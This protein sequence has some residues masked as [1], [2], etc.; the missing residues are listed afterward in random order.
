LIFGFRNFGVLLIVI[1]KEK[2]NESVGSRNSDSS[3]YW[4][5]VEVPCVYVRYG[6][7]RNLK[8]GGGRKWNTIKSGRLNPRAGV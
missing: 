4:K 7:C 3:L 6:P 8:I 5:A 1:K 2:K